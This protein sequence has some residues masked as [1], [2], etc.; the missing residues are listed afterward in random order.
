MP[1]PRSLLKG[2]AKTVETIKPRGGRRAIAFDPETRGLAVRVTAKGRKT[3]TIVARDPTGRQVW[4]EVGDATELTLDEAR[5]LA[6]EGVRR[7]KAG[8]EPFP[9]VDPPPAPESF[10]DVA[11]NF[12]KRHVHAKNRE[13]RSAGE[14]ERQFE[15]YLLPRWKDRPFTEIRRGDVVRLLDELEDGA[16]PVM[17]DRVLATLSKVFRW[18]AAR[19]DDYMPPSVPGMRRTRPQERARTRTLDDEEIRAL[20][21]ALDDMGRRGALVK[22]LLLTGQRRAKVAAMRW[23]DIDADGVWTIPAEE[24]EKGNAG[25]LPLPESVREI[26]DALPPVAGNPYVFPGRA[27]GHVG[28]YGPLKREIDRR[29]AEARGEPLAPWVLHDLRRTAKSLM[30]RAGVRPDVSERVLGHVIRGVEGVYDR[31]G[32][33]AE[34]ADA[35]RRLAALVE[36]ILDPPA[37]NVVPIAA[38]G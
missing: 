31:H 16:G 20:W 6:R 2:F 26:I 1:A 5:E 9:R 23:E 14:I 28:G 10:G 33:E 37:E 7:I 18:Y 21:A 12:L 3:Y 32:Y 27:G 36:R 19:V 17:A 4:R 25:R 8:L 35:L 15:R 29:I 34:K 13:L 38:E 22:L 24:R 30:Q 11:A